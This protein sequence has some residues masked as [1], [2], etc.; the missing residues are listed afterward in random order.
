MVLFL[1]SKLYVQS[2]YFVKL[3]FSSLTVL[4]LYKTTIKTYIINFRNNSNRR[5]SGVSGVSGSGG[6][7]T[8]FDYVTN[9]IVEVMR[10]DA[11]ERAERDRDR[12]RDRVERAKPMAFPTTAYAYP[13]SALNVATPQGE[14]M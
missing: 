3:F 2:Q 13:Y 12:D 14:G 4:K 11:D 8:A 5:Y 7:L 6:V 10:S 9:R 1:V